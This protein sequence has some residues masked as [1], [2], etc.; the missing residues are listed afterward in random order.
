[1]MPPNGPASVVI[2]TRKLWASRPAS[3]GSSEPISR[4]KWFS[5]IPQG[6]D[7]SRRPAP[8]QRMKRLSV[9]SSSCSSPVS[10]EVC[11]VM[12][13]RVTTPSGTQAW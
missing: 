7:I 12:A 5:P 1:M 3:E 2:S 13:S 6:R 9:L 8:A 10:S 4:L 11:S